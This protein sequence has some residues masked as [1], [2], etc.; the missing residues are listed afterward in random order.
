M[1]IPR[2]LSNLAP[3]A[4]TSGVLGAD[5]G[6]TG[7]TSPGANGN[8]LQSNGTAWTS[9][10]FSAGKAADVQTFTSSG[11]WTK[12]SGFSSKARVLIECWGGGGS[13]A[14]GSQNTSAA[15][16][17]GGGAYNYRWINLSDLSATETVTIG[18]GGS[19]R[20]TNGAQG[21]S[22]GNTTFGSK[23]T[24]Y[25]G[26]GGTSQGGNSFG[27][28][29][30]GQTSAGNS[31]AGPGGP[32]YTQQNSPY[33]APEGAGGYSFSTVQGISGV[34]AYYKGGGA[35]AQYWSSCLPQ[36]GGNGGDSVWGGG[37]GG[38]GTNAGNAPSG[39]VSSFAGSGGSGGV[40]ATSANNGTTPAGGGGGTYYGATSG[41][42]GNGYCIV[43]VF[44]G[45]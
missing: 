33:W 40:N 32:G 27:G 31:S 37:G 15:G 24:A 23:V 35:G 14:K 21:I 3:G 25:G 1:T 9:A 41:S 43:T 29:G 22:G 28:G 42:G 30:G 16:G 26:G 12:P 5:K 6:G 44:D 39:G 34:S 8:I 17:G 2:N 7:L 19:A 38:A 45:A 10:S 11:T 20:T 18:S 4:S 36:S 13:G